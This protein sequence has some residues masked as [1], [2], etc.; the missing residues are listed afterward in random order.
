MALTATLHRFR[1]ELSDI[2]RGV[3]ES[4]D[5]RVAR[6][7]SEDEARV[8]IRVL[9]HAI[10]FEAGLGFGKGLSTVDEPALWAKS[11]TGEIATWI[12]VGVPAADR[13]HRASK[14]ARR[15]LVFTHKQ[16]AALRQAWSGQD[17]HGADRIEL[18]RLDPAQVSALAEQL[19]RTVSWFVTIQD[20]LLS[21]A[22]GETS[23]DGPLER[24]SLS[25]FVTREG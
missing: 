10:A 4:L 15:V 5:L 14:R 17:I 19:D 8:V 24:T 9:A 18:V 11:D 21:V 7:P 2:D 23:V 13:L 6:H 16:E 3:Y 20:D 1:I 25:H 12:D 22:H